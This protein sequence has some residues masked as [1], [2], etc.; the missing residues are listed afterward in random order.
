MA[1]GLRVFCGGL[2]N[3]TVVRVFREHHHHCG[4]CRKCR[5]FAPQPA[6][7]EGHRL[8]PTESGLPEFLV[9]ESTFRPSEDTN[10]RSGAGGLDLSGKRIAKSSFF[11][12]NHTDVCIVCREY[13]GKRQRL[14]EM[15]NPASSALLHGGYQDLPCAGVPEGE[16]FGALRMHRDYRANAQF[17]GFFEE[18]FEAA[19]V[20]EQ[21][22]SYAQSVGGL[23]DFPLSFEYPCAPATLQT[24]TIPTSFAVN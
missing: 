5:R 11:V 15:R 23:T 14:M 19:A 6:W 22:D 21:S 16:R 2:P 1:G 8:I 24:R 7:S 10:T 12:R 18:D 20:L 9:R 13:V 4:R 3:D 17:D